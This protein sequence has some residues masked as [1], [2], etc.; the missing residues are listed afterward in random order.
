MIR[1]KSLWIIACMLALAT[2]MAFG[3]GA[4]FNFVWTDVNSPGWYELTYC[5]TPPEWDVVLQDGT[6]VRLMKDRD[7]S[8]TTGLSYSPAD[9]VCTIG[10]LGVQGEVTI[11]EFVFNSATIPRALGSFLSPYIQYMGGVPAFQPVY[12]LVG[13]YDT[14]GVD[15]VFVPMWASCDFLFSSGPSQ[16]I[17]S[18][19]NDGAFGR[20]C[21]TRVGCCE[22]PPSCEAVQ[23]SLV[24]GFEASTTDCDSIRMTWDAYDSTATAAL[25]YDGVDS[26]IIKRAGT[27]IGSVPWWA[28]YFA[29]YPPAEQTYYDFTIQVKRYCSETLLSEADTSR[30]IMPRYPSGTPVLQDASDSYCDSVVCYYDM[31]AGT[32]QGWD[33]TALLRNGLIVTYAPEGFGG[34][35]GIRIVHYNAPIGPANY[36]VAGWNHTCG[37]GAQS[38]ASSGEAGGAPPEVQNV[39]ASD[40]DCTHPTYVSITWTDLNVN[41]TGYRVYRDGN[42]IGPL[43]S[44]NA[45]SYYDYSGAAGQPY[46]YSVRAFSACDSSQTVTPNTGTLPV[47]PPQV[48]GFAASDTLCDM[49]RL[50]WNDVSDETG[51]AVIKSAPALAETVYVGPNTTQYDVVGTFGTTTIVPLT[52][53]TF[54]VAAGNA[55]GFGTASTTNTGTLQRRPNPVTN[56]LPGTSTCNYAR[57]TWSQTGISNEK[58]FKIYRDAVEIDTANIDATFYNDT[59]ATPGVAHN[60]TVAAYNQ[61]GDTTAVGPVAATRL[62]PPDAPTTFNATDAECGMVTCTWDDVADET[63]YTVYRDD[64]AARTVT[65]FPVNPNIT[66]YNDVT[67]QAGEVYTYWVTATNACGESDSSNFDDGALLPLPGQPVI[68]SSDVDCDSVYF[69][70]NY[71]TEVDSFN[72][73][74]DGVYIGT[75]TDTCFAYAPT[76]SL[77]HFYQVVAY[78]DCGNGDSSLVTTLAR[79]GLPGMPT[80]FGTMQGYNCDNVTLIWMGD[81]YGHDGFLIYEGAL[82]RAT[83]GPTDTFWVDD[84]IAPGEWRAYWL[85]VFNACDTIAYSEVAGQRLAPPVMVEDVAATD[86]ICAQVTITWTDPNDTE[87]GFQIVRDDMIARTVDTVATI[88]D[89]DAVTYDDLTASSGTWYE[90][91]VF[92][93]N[94]CGLSDPSEADSGVVLPLPDAVTGFTVAE[95]CSLLWFGWDVSEFAEYYQVYRDLGELV[96]TVTDTLYGTT[97]LGQHNW[98]V[99]PQNTCGLGV[100]SD[101]LNRTALTAPL[102]ID[103]LLANDDG[104]ARTQV[105]NCDHVTLTWTDPAN[106]DTIFI[107]RDATQIDYVLFGVET[108]TDDLLAP[109]DYEY[110]VIANNECG[111]TGESNHVNATVYPPPTAP[112]NVVA[113]DTSCAQVY[114]T[115]DAATGTFDEYIIYADSVEI[116]R[117]FAGTTALF[118][119]TAIPGDTALYQVSAYDDVCG[120]SEY[121]AGDEGT[122]LEGPS[123]PADVAASDDLCDMITVTWTAST[124]TFTEYRIYRDGTLVGTVDGATTTFDDDTLSASGTYSYTITAWSAECGETADSDPDDGTMLPQMGQATGLTASMDDCDGVVLNWDAYEGADEYYVYREGTAIDTVDTNEAFDDDVVRGV[125]HSYTVSAVNRCNEG[126]QSEAANGMRKDFPAAI[127]NLTASD[128]LCDEICLEWDDVEEETGYYIYRETLLLDSTVMDDAD[129]CDTTV[130]PGTTY[131]YV[132]RAKNECGEGDPSES[133]PGVGIAGLLPVS[134][135]ITTPSCDD[136]TLTWDDIEGETGYQLYYSID[137]SNF[138]ELAT[139]EADVVTYVDTAIVAGECHEYTVAGIN[140][141]G[142]GAESSVVEGC[143]KDVPIIVPNVVASTTVCDSVL[144]SWDDVGTETSFDIQ[145]DFVDLIIGL[146]A[147][148]LSYY[149]ATAE[150]NVSYS[151]V[152]R[153]VNEC[154]VGFFSDEAF[155]MAADIPA[156]VQ[157]VQATSDQCSTVVIT[158][159]DLPDETGYSIS[160]GSDPYTGLGSV[161]A[162]VTEFTAVGFV[163]AENF[164][165]VASNQCG[166]SIRSALAPGEGLDVP[167]VVMNLAFTVNCGAV[168]L[169]WDFPATADS[170]RVLRRADGI[171][172]FDTLATTPLSSHSDEPG[173]GT[174]EYAILALNECGFAPDISNIVSVEIIPALDQVVNFTASHDSCHCVYLSWDDVENE[175]QYQIYCDAELIATTVAN[176][177]DTSI[178]DGTT[179]CSYQVR[180]INECDEGPFSDAV[181][182]SYDVEPEAPTGVSAS[183]DNCDHIMVIWDPVDFCD[184]YLVFCDDDFVDTVLSTADEFLEHDTTA[185]TYDYH[186][187][188]YNHCG[189]SPNSATDSG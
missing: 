65:T 133:I 118:H 46:S 114:I 67:A 149:D 92:A 17:I 58:G 68:A 23:D 162:D 146:P 117:V 135:V 116:N 186:V 126:T 81:A 29:H 127:T 170:F 95:Q 151:Y 163:G 183:D 90:Y 12:L 177:T 94:E 143:R 181:I 179:P 189:N 107:Y 83:L 109:A 22:P 110:Y 39:N 15:S 45:N 78:N 8:G 100:S 120:E 34:Q 168:N 19:P 50:T 69:C 16:E 167:P 73:F 72:V 82:L 106:A 77:D 31:P 150:P 10:T 156:Q 171:T 145:R 160:Y 93:Y 115:W 111:A 38:N 102:A 184:G 176:N 147:D 2:G 103:D 30:G 159:D 14:T 165:V 59:N 155:G 138:L 132:V 84:T 99:I 53:Y 26:L 11:N 175:T 32:P 71:L 47:L 125:T 9:T 27:K 136:V 85:K 108:Y 88:T 164:S 142:V 36:T 75:T 188:A 101:T 37:I 18:C 134:N 42:R 121:S 119:T 74:D 169:T 140:I 129:F 33:S 1:M 97:D 113:S 86:D 60:Y 105:D 64:G 166:T 56:L 70:W 24:R 182:G 154:G 153:G 152:V 61:C 178:C 104:G 91:T 123:I 141:C 63:G 128:T 80:G 187:V 157:N 98:H 35:T 21:W 161:G 158:W 3:Q 40:S 6:P 79:L 174:W 131:N 137:G 41:E 112:T 55:C 20:P 130:V 139:V 25:G 28:T 122:R 89:P 48:T 43:L 172:D 52:A 173:V 144:I 13:C 62:A 57:I 4:V 51:Y 5:D 66:T 185:G 87:E 44:A 148:C 124:G 49:I 7:N 96:A 54:K 180:A 76:D